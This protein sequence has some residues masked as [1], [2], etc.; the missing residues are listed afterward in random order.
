MARLP[1]DREEAVD[2]ISELPLVLGAVGVLAAVVAMARAPAERR[3][4]NWS[5]LMGAA[6]IGISALL[7]VLLPPISFYPS[8]LAGLVVAGALTGLIAAAIV[9]IR[10][11]S[12][13]GVVLRGGRWH[14]LV[15]ATALLALQGARF[16]QSTT[17]ALLV[18]AALVTSSAF[19]IAASL[20]I[21]ARVALARRRGSPDASLQAA[22]PVAV[23]GRT[24]SMPEHASSP[25]PSAA[26]RPG[27]GRAAPDRAVFCSTCGAGV[28]PGARFCSQ[29]GTR[30]SWPAGPAPVSVPLPTE[31]AQHERRSRRG[32][33]ISTALL[34]GLT[35]AAA[36]LWANWSTIEGRLDMVAGNLEQTQEQSTAEEGISATDTSEVDKSSLNGT[37][38]FDAEHYDAT[39]D[40]PTDFVAGLGT[41]TVDLAADPPVTGTLWLSFA[42]EGSEE[43]TDDWVFDI[44]SPTQ[45]VWDESSQQGTVSLVITSDQSEPV[46]EVAV[47]RSGA[48]QFSNPQFVFVRD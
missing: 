6:G 18:T 13:G 34:I 16:A 35:A 4:S 48:I 39:T 12:D 37:Y 23:A 31:P 44:S 19:V 47:I 3:L 32:L 2:I 15:P 17:W 41:I 20:V 28:S 7:A 29:C 8:V 1:A 27:G 5:A 42:V 46:E 25:P 36:A 11:G 38:S 10:R 43:G 30:A 9:R 24:A 45:P 21:A 22:V 40:S 14:L 33:A 26:G